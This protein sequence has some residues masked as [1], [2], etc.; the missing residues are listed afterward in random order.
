FDGRVRGFA[1]MG[2]LSDAAA[3]AEQPDPGGVFVFLGSDMEGMFGHRCPKCK[4]YWRSNGFPVTWQM[5]CP[6]CGLH[7]PSH[8]FLTPGQLKYARECYNLIVEAMDGP[9]GD[10]TVDMDAVAD[11]AGKDVEKPKFYYAEQ[12]MQ[13]RYKCEACGCAQDILGK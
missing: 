8:A 6:Y 9:D 3:D 7:A 12:S 10:H 5:I 11:A 2:G 1:P 4:E 13:H